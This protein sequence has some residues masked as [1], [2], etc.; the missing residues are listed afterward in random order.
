M[1][2]LRQLTVG[3]LVILK[4]KYMLLNKVREKGIDLF[5]KIID[6]MEFKYEAHEFIYHADYNTFQ[7]IFKFSF[8]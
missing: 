6:D 2:R 5:I 3:L 7:L 8:L 1:L 4:I